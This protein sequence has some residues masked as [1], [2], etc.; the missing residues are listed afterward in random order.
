MN[1]YKIKKKKLMFDL[2]KL[3]L[4]DEKFLDNNLNNQIEGVESYCKKDKIKKYI[5]NKMEEEYNIDPG[6]K[7]ILDIM[8]ENGN[9]DNCI[10]DIKIDFFNKCSLLS[11]EVK[12]YLDRASDIEVKSYKEKKS[13]NQFKDAVL[14]LKIF[15]ELLVNYKNKKLLADLYV[16]GVINER[17]ENTQLD[18][19]EI[20]DNNIPVINEYIHT[21]REIQRLE[22][23]TNNTTRYEDDPIEDI[24]D[25]IKFKSTQRKKNICIKNVTEL[26]EEIYDN[27]SLEDKDMV[28]NFE[29]ME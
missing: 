3:N 6:L 24:K 26:L 29:V 7:Y 16:D 5:Y 11:N 18:N 8:F 19:L 12:G 10:I 9:M 17:N 2:K 15:D 25:I 14:K 27:N 4:N 28:M 22:Y 23:N 1:I 20:I 13:D 21:Y